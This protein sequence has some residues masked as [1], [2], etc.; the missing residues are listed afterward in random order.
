MQN[1]L[2]LKCCESR[3][4]LRSKV[5]LRHFSKTSNPFSQ[6]T[7]QT[8]HGLEFKVDTYK[9]VQILDDVLADS[10]LDH[11]Q[12]L[13]NLRN[14][15]DEWKSEQKTCV[16]IR[17][18]VD[19]AILL[20]EI[21]NMN[22]KPHHATSEYFLLTSWF[23]D[24]PSKLPPGPSHYVGVAGFVLNSKEEILCIKEK[25]GPAKAISLWKLPGGLVNQGENLASAAVREVKEETGLDTTFHKLATMTHFHG[26]GTRMPRYFNSDLYC[27]CVLKA[28][29]EAQILVP[30]PDEIEEVRWIHCEE[31]LA[32]PFYQSPL[33]GETM[34]QALLVAQRKDSA[35]LTSEM[36]D[37]KIRP[38][39]AEVLHPKL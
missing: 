3:T 4:P 26:D 24:R 2:F 13:V 20:P 30:Q 37:F 25:T 33:F 21:L 6:P 28:K 23:P 9:G 16:W 38:G 27:I 5:L 35:G 39:N 31:V 1:N 11:K 17:V 34:K 29:N 22:F 32:M 14:A 12:F 8:L 18:P 7:V 36:L 10:D 15:V 19:K